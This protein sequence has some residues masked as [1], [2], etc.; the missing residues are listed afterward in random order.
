MSDVESEIW[1]LTGMAVRMAVDM[2]LHLV[3]T[4]CDCPN[5]R[6]SRRHHHQNPTFQPKTNAS[7][8]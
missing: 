1:M 5:R 7:I 8:A 6:L 2:G 3:G 4:V